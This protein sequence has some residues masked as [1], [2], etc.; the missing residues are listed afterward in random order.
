MNFVESGF[1]VN[2]FFIRDSD[3][4]GSFRFD[5]LGKKVYVN[6]GVTSITIADLFSRWEDWLRQDDNLKW[7][8]AMRY[9]GKDPI[10]GGETGTTFFMMNGWKLVYDPNVVAI[11]GVLFSEDLP[12]P[13]WNAAGNP[14]YPATVSSL[15]NSA[16][17]YQNVVTGTALTAEQTANAVWQAATRSL[18]ASLDPSVA[19]IVDAIIANA[20]TLTTGKFLALKD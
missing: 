14:L 18:T 17:S 9:S 13:Y 1:V 6:D 7:Q 19:Q 2:G 11:S 15:V 16:V 20:Q 3:T 10:P 4:Q 12:T 8:Q 5:G